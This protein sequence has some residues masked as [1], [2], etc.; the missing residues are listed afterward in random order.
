[1]QRKSVSIL[2]RLCPPKKTGICK[3]SHCSTINSKPTQRVASCAPALSPETELERHRQA[4]WLTYSSSGR[5]RKRN[6]TVSGPISFELS[7]ETVSQ[8]SRAAASNAA[9]SILIIPII[10]CIALGW[11]INSP[12]RRGTICQH[13]PKRSV[14]Q[15][16]AIA[17][18]PS[19]NLSQ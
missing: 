8:S 12:M 9:R 6:Q 2:T 13:R 14:S 16:Q 1:M 15:P 11:L 4:S 10:A 19:I 7:R 17:L 18:P 3:Y 5:N